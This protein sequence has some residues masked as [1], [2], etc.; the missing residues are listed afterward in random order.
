MAKELLNLSANFSFV[1][2][3]QPFGGEARPHVE[4]ILVVSEPKYTVDESGR[5][6][7]SRVND[8]LRFHTNA[9]GLRLLAGAF[10]DWAS[11]MEKAEAGVAAV[12]EEFTS[13]QGPPEKP[14]GKDD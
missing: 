12:I 5:L 10:G 7:K 4:V 14:A 3:E 2:S 8:T 13:N 11:E 6:V 9:K 1:P